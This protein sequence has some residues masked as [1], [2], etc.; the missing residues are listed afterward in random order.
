MMAKANYGRHLPAFILLFL[1]KGPNYG[2]EIINMMETHLPFNLSDGPATYRA[3]KDLEKSGS[4]ESYWNTENAGAPR[5][6]YTLTTKG[7][8][9]LREYEA[10]IKARK[11]NFEY[12]LAELAKLDI[13]K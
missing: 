1:A 6:Y 5:K 7:Y 9:T 8:E 13:D 11:S 3:L 2:S 10:D 4:V 12:F